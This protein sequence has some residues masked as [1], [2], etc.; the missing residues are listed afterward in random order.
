[1]SILNCNIIQ[2][3]TQFLESDYVIQ[4]TYK[5]LQYCQQVTAFLQI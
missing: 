5:L 1:M 3:S 2:K 4:I